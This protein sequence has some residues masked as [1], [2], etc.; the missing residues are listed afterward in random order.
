ML[1]FPAGF[2]KEMGPA[3]RDNSSLDNSKWFRYK[4]NA[5]S[6]DYCGPAA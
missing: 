2:V 5:L 1:A 3:P 4:N 6:N